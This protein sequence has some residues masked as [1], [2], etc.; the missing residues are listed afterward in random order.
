[1]DI[2]I[3]GTGNTAAVLGHKLKGAGHVIVQIFGRNA[4]AA[5]ELAYELDTESTAYWS[6][7]NRQA[8]VYIL[9]VSDIAKALRNRRLRCRTCPCL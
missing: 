9:A 6:V 7:V 3:I 2:V 1:M 8:D 5:S 4:S